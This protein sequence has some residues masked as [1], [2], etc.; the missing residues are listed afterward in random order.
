MPGRP[1]LRLA[2][3]LL[4]VA[5]ASPAFALANRVFVSARWAT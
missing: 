4:S 2:V 1:S 3:A 5:A